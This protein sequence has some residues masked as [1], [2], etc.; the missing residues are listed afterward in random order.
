V[1][2]SVRNQVG[3]PGAEMDQSGSLPQTLLISIIL[4]RIGGLHAASK[5]MMRRYMNHRYG[6][7]T[8]PSILKRRYGMAPVGIIIGLPH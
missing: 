7:T 6:S 2:I 1:R 3:V 8:H 4:L 5:K